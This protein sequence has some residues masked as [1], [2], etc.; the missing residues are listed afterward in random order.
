MATCTYYCYDTQG[1]D[2]GTS[3]ISISVGGTFTPSSHVPSFAYYNY[4]GGAPT[5]SHTVTGDESY[6]LTYARIY[7]TCIYYCYDEE[8]SILIDTRS[9]SLR[10]GDGFTPSAHIPSINGYSYDYIYPD[11]GSESHTV[12]SNEQYDVYYIPSSSVWIYTGIN[13]EYDGWQRAI[14]YIYTSNGWQK[15]RAYIYTGT[16]PEDGWQPC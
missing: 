7:Y 6:Y 3:S 11:P 2:L 14:P 8:S 12:V 5:T 4:Q 15:A 9:V 1:V 10:A 16:G 13:N